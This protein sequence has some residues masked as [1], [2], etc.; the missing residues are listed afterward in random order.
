VC[1][2]C[3]AQSGVRRRNPHAGEDARG[4]FF[5]LLAGSSM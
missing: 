4:A 3:R 5:V 1:M 2:S